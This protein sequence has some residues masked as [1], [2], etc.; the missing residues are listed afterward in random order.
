MMTIRMKQIV[1][2]FAWKMILYFSHAMI[3]PGVVGWYGLD[4]VYGLAEKIRIMFLTSP[5]VG[6]VGKYLYPFFF[7]I[8][9]KYTSN[10]GEGATH[11]AMK[12]EKNFWKRNIVL[13]IRDSSWKCKTDFSH[14]QF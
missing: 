6:T 11:Y 10:L 9:C 3:P 8:N 12:R 13:K 14:I 7:N 2:I 1:K 4:L 5:H